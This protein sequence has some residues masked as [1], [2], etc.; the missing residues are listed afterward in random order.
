MDK[1]YYKVT[2]CRPDTKEKLQE[3]MKNERPC[4][5]CILLDPNQGSNL[6]GG[7]PLT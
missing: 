3:D 7:N 1:D 4:G 5:F 6:S 2:I